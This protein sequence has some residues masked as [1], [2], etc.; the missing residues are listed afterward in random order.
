MFRHNVGDRAKDRI[1]GL[2]GIISSRSEHLFGCNRYWI[3]PE[4]L[5]EGKP[6]DG[7]WF[8]EDSIVVTQAAAIQPQRYRV[9]EAEEQERRPLRRAGG[10]SNQ[11]ASTTGPVGR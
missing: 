2:E 4:Q 10:P 6:V 7:R 5:H 11:P 3:E 8:D 1:T 9:V